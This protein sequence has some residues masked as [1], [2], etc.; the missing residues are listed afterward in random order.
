MYIYPHNKGINDEVLKRRK[1]THVK[2]KS[3][4][5]LEIRRHMIC[6]YERDFTVRFL[7]LFLALFN[8]RQGQGSES[9]KFLKLNINSPP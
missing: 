4:N 2:L 8:K 6:T 7:N 5:I 3:G 9:L 1:H